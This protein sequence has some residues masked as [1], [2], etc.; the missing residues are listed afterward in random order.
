MESKLG[1]S[2]RK[3]KSGS[4][5]KKIKSKQVS[6]TTK[7]LNDVTPLSNHD[8]IKLYKDLK[9]FRGVFMIDELP[10][11]TNVLLSVLIFLKNIG[12]H[13]I[14]YIKDHSTSFV[15][16]SFSEQPPKRLV[17]YLTTLSNLSATIFYN[18]G[19]I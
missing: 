7:K 1:T 14:C 9:G 5:T 8:I 15:F 11:H 12:T 18:D 4:G 17:N 3:C 16:D 2:V 10:T 19:R 13:W 6:I